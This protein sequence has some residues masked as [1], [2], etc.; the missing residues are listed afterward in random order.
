[1]VISVAQEKIE[2]IAQHNEK[3]CDKSFENFF[4]TQYKK[5]KPKIVPIK[6]A[7]IEAFSR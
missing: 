1:M 5:A 7:N 6:K 3:Y 4:G 2:V